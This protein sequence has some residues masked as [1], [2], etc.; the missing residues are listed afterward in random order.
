MREVPFRSNHQCTMGILPLECWPSYVPRWV[1]A[2]LSLLLSRGWRNEWM[3]ERMN[4]IHLAKAHTSLLIWNTWWR[5]LLGMQWKEPGSWC[6]LAYIC[7]Q[8]IH[9]LPELLTPLHADR[10]SL[11]LFH[12]QVWKYNFHQWV[13]TYVFLRFC[14]LYSTLYIPRERRKTET[15][16]RILLIFPLLFIWNRQAVCHN[17][18]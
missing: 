8:H 13:H 4:G 5:A 10:L 12:G 15:K 3:N 6:T 17:G 11:L 1:Y 2:S 16:V 18:N 7:T 14:V 9:N